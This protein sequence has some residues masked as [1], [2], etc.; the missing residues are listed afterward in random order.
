MEDEPT[1]LLRPGERLIEICGRLERKLEG[2][3]VVLRTAD[4]V[5]NAPTET[6]ILVPEAFQSLEAELDIERIVTA[7]D[8]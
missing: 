7:H 1:P 8:C 6:R 4:S 5:S 3:Q 2:I